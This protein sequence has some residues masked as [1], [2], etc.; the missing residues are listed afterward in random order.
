MTTQDFPTCSQCGAAPI[1]RDQ[2]SCRFCSTLLSWSEYDLRSRR[3][4]VLVPAESMEDAISKVEGSAEFRRASLGGKGSDRSD[5]QR[6]GR[7]RRQ[8]KPK[9]SSLTVDDD[10]AAQGIALSAIM[11]GPIMAAIVHFAGAGWIQFLLVGAVASAFA[12]WGAR[13]SSKT[14]ERKWRSAIPKRS[15]ILAAGILELGSPRAKSQR[16]R[17]LV[18]DVTLLARRG[19][20]RKVIADVSL[21]LHAGDVGIAMTLGRSMRTFRQMAFVAEQG[22]R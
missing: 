13:R 15:S 2:E 11:L 8:S 20:K 22:Q 12:I 18:R 7:R 4:V 16:D 5:R 14:Q 9:R 19:R 21:D 3:V 10:L 17:T 6:S 1:S